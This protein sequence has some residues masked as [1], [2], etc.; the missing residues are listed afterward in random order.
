M[1]QNAGHAGQ[2]N[3]PFFSHTANDEEN[4]R[5]GEELRT[6]QMAL[7][8]QQHENKEDPASLHRLGGNS[9][10]VHD[11]NKPHYSFFYLMVTGHIQSGTFE[12]KDGICCSFDVNSTDDGRDWQLHTV[13]EDN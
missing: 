11:P 9:L 5:L 1:S 2:Q 7:E 6:R 8:E 4:Q 3:N 13:S 10:N 12:D